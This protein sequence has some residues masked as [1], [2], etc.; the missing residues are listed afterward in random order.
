MKDEI[1]EVIEYQRLKKKRDVEFSVHTGFGLLL[2]STIK[3]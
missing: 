3:L 1:E 2:Q